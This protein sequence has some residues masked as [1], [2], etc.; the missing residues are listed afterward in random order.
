MKFT[1]YVG[2][3]QEKFG[4]V[5]FET[6]KEKVFVTNKTGGEILQLLEEGNTLNNI[7]KILENEY[8]EDST[9]GE[10]C[11]R[12]D[13]VAFIDELEQNGILSNR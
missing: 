12:D 13:V 8:A 7:T 4:A 1:K 10:R 5:V 11:I 2:V 6:L 9:S 3:R